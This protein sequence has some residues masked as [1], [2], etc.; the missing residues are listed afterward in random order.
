MV[1]EFTT[2]D[3]TFDGGSAISTLADGS[4]GASGTFDG[5]LAGPNGTDIGANVVMTG[6]AY[7]QMVEYE[8]ATY[9]VT[10]PATTIDLPGVGQV[11]VPGGTS[12]GT[13]EALTENNTDAVQEIING[14]GVVPYLEYNPADIPTGAVVTGVRTEPVFYVSDFE[15]RE[16]G[17][18]VAER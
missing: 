13:A 14:G 4:D 3:G 7:S 6:P 8:I 18:V 16:I 9:T 1:I 15:A 12:V 11:Q 2:A 5:F 17:V 10:T